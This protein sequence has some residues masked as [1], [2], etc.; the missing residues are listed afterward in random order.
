MYAPVLTIVYQC[1]LKD[2][3]SVTMARVIDYQKEM[4]IGKQQL[5]MG[6]FVRWSFLALSPALPA[7]PL[8]PEADR[9][10]KR[11]FQVWL[12]T[13][14]TDLQK[15]GRSWVL[16]LGRNTTEFLKC[17]ATNDRM[18]ASW[19]RTRGE[20]P[21]SVLA[22]ETKPSEGHKE[23]RSKPGLDSTSLRCPG[24]GLSHSATRAPLVTAW[25][26]GMLRGH[27]G[28]KRLKLLSVVHF[29]ILHYKYNSS[30]IRL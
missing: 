7:A 30:R 21:L 6:L 25:K 15:P 11:A 20:Q 24:R 16:G 26:G 1:S 2:K 12:F 19:L 5:V 17:F 29:W 14:R 13:A 3:I 28:W 23:Q 9:A 8:Q 4:W 10:G 18:Q 27:K 22:G